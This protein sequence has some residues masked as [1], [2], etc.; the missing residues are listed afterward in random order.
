MTPAAA[1]AAS[2][3]YSFGDIA[4][5]SLRFEAAP[6]ERN[7]LVVSSVPAE[8]DQAP[9]K[10]RLHDAGAPVTTSSAGCVSEDLNTVLCEV[11]LPLTADL[12]DGDDTFSSSLGRSAF[13][14]GGS[15]DDVLTGDPA[16][17]AAAAAEQYGEDSSAGEHSELDGGPGDDVLTGGADR[18]KLWG[19]TGDDRLTGNA[20]FD[21]LCGGPP[22]GPTGCLPLPGSGNDILD[23]GR[24]R[25]YL[26]GGD[27]SD[28]LTGGPG[29]DI[30]EAGPGND[31]V[32]A[33]G[34]SASD[35]DGSSFEQVFAGA[36]NDRILSRDGQ[37]DELYCQGGQDTLERD[38]FDKAV[39]LGCAAPAGPSPSSIVAPQSV[40]VVRGRALTVRLT[41]PALMLRGCSGTVTVRT[42]GEKRLASGR[43]R[44]IAAG[45]GRTARLK[46]GPTARRRLARQASRGV[47][48]RLTNTRA[49]ESVA[50]RVETRARLR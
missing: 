19:G 21:F 10:V 3:T 7:A 35:P 24:F 36:G 47:T 26:A 30:L 20:G 48:V 8:S 44:A 46:L 50:K 31:L 42:R 9:P 39:D 6:G 49:P 5:Q 14:S 32:D 13:V 17:G 37:F 41:C 11:A 16:P 28:W 4:Q 40:R 25:D 29:A 2:V 18:D 45:R 34:D 15:G 23:G 22:Q 12:G 1:N 33:T 27:G 38:P 43:Y